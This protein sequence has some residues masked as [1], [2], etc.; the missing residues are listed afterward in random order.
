M[1]LRVRYCLALGLL[2]SS[3]TGVA[4]QVPPIARD[5]PPATGLITG[6]VVDAQGTP[7]EGAIVSLRGGLIEIGTQMQAGALA[8]GL[9][10]TLTR[11]G[12]RFLFTGLAAASYS[13]EVTK[14]GYL[15]GAFGRRRPGGVGQS[16]PL[17]ADE[18]KTGVR[19]QLWEF[20]AITG[21]VIDEAGEPVVGVQVQAMRRVFESGYPKLQTPGVSAS[22]DDRGEF[23]IDGLVPGAVTVCVATTPVAL[24]T[25]V[26][27]ALAQALAD[28]TIA[29]FRRQIG[30]A[31][32]PGSSG[33]RIGD[34]VV[35][36]GTNQRLAP[37]WSGEDGKTFAYPTTCHPNGPPSLSETVQ[38]DSGAERRV[39]IRLA[40]RAAA[41]VAGH[42]LGPEGPMARVPIRLVAGYTAQLTGEQGFET[43]ITMT[44][45]A[46]AFRFIGVSEGDY[47][48]LALKSPEAA[49]VQ[50]GPMFAASPDPA[51]WARV[52]VAVTEKGVTDLEVTMQRGFRVTG[53]LEFDGTSPKPSPEMMERY[54]VVFAPAEGNGGR[55]S[56]ALRAGI[57]REG[58]IVSPEMPPGRHV[59]WFVAF[60]DDRIASAAW[61]T[62]GATIDGRDASNIPYELKGDVTTLVVTRTDRPTMIAGT[63]RDAQSQADADAVVLVFPVDPQRWKDF[64]SSS[65]T[66]RQA[67]AT[68]TGGYRIVGVP[69]GDYF[70][71]GVPEAEAGDWQD[72]AVLAVLARSASRVTIGRNEQK[73]MDV[74]SIAMPRGGR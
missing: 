61:V 43:A 27:D 20:A 53:R 30:T 25:G 55:Q 72:P 73:T 6:I 12:G 39:D 66:L 34:V 3:L 21:S 58:R 36:P 14:S 46:G 28:G 15:P 63:V 8:G 40:P 52:P 26:V 24:P 1:F 17:A 35:Q 16:I 60:A 45:A 13:I 51:Y 74:V 67:R 69:V 9:R 29:E 2:A 31:P 68:E 4:A 11:S 41:D 56:N 59:V 19:I 47:T 44:D 64:G 62:V 7:V 71:V 42:L 70:V 57:D 50:G 37:V 65:R 23:R 48:L 22:T 38:L 5:Q 32:M 18:R 49:P 54:G 33:L 10:N